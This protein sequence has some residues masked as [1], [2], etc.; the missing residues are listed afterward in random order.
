MSNEV[1]KKQDYWCTE[2]KKGR[3]PSGK[4]LVL[5][6]SCEGLELDPSLLPW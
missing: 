4:E 1:A 5:V 2:G 6:S 3:E